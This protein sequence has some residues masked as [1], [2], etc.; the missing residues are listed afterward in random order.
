M[1]LSKAMPSGVQPVHFAVTIYFQV[2]IFD[3][4]AHHILQLAR[5]HNSALLQKSE[6]D[7]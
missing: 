6:E 3:V 5:G 2:D 4:R 7:R 1:S